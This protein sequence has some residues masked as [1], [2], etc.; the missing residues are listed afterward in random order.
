MYKINVD[1]QKNRLYLTL[2]GFFTPEEILRCGDETIA[3]TR[4]LK[5]GYDVVTDITEFKPGSAEVAKD[6]ERVQAHFIK[7]GARQGVRVVGQN[8]S[9]SMQFDRVGKLAGYQSTPVRTMVEA[10]TLLNAL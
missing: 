2:I 9:S 3:A 10:E 5:A 4:K 1:A 8:S 7:T 6:I